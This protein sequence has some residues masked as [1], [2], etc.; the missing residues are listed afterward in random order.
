MRRF[1][2]LLLALTMLAGISPA[3][4]WA[5]EVSDEKILPV[6]DGIASENIAVY[7]LPYYTN[8]D[9]LS[10]ALTGQ[11]I[12]YMNDGDESSYAGLYIDPAYRYL[13]IKGA[14]IF[15]FQQQVCVTDFV[16][17]MNNSKINRYSIECSNDRENW[18]TLAT[19]VYPK[20]IERISFPVAKARW[21]RLC[22][23]S[24]E[25]VPQFKEIEI[26][27]ESEEETFEDKS[28]LIPEKSFG[29]LTAHADKQLLTEL[30]EPADAK[31]VHEDENGD[32]VYEA[33]DENG[34]TLASWGRVGYKNGEEPIPDI[35]T[36]VTVSPNGKDDTKAIQAA[37]DQVAAMPLKENGFRGAIYLEKGTYY[38]SDAI[39][40]NH[41]GIV[42]RGAGNTESGED[43]TLL[44]GTAPKQYKMFNFVGL[45]NQNTYEVVGREYE[46][47]GDYLGTG[48]TEIPL[49]STEGLKKGDKIIVYR[50]P[51]EAWISSLRM[52][53]LGGLIV[54]DGKKPWNY[55]LYYFQFERK[56]ADVK[57]NSIVIDIPL[58]Q[59]MERAYGM[60]T[61]YK[62]NAP[63]RISNCGIEDLS[64][65][66]Y[67]DETVVSSEGTLIDEQ[68]L[69]TGVFFDWFEDGWARNISVKHVVYGA[70]MVDD[71]GKNVTVSD[72]SVTDFVSQIT[73][74][75]RYSFN[76]D[77]QQSLVINCYAKS[78]RHDYVISARAGRGPNAAVN[79]VA[80]DQRNCTE[81]HQRY[82]TG[83]LWDNVICKGNDT[84]GMCAIQRGA[85]GTGQGWSGNHMMFWNCASAFIFIM[86]PPGGQNFAVGNGEILMLEDEENGMGVKI[87]EVTRYLD[88]V[89]AVSGQQFYYQG[90]PFVG[91]GYFELNDRRAS[92]SSLYE[93]Q[94]V[95]AYKDLSY[96]F[97]EGQN[98]YV[99]LNE[100]RETENS[101]CLQGETM[102]IPL[103]QVQ[104]VLDGKS[105]EEILTLAA[106][107]VTEKDGVTYLPMRKVFEAAGLNVYYDEGT[108]TV[109]SYDKSFMQ[110]E[111]YAKVLKSINAKIL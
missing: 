5:E 111:D 81:T 54:G 57:E 3:G 74:G 62:Y 106:G 92:I 65:D 20:T 32:L 6:S 76:L 2:P 23:L 15:D 18:T 14:I 66:S 91:N 96:F 93:R 12:G 94:H 97:R 80:E 104:E 8:F 78:G 75:R 22:I 99:Y 39:N 85:T 11:P 10:R 64:I 48:T 70:V 45:E 67:Y 16:L 41:S 55:S 30:Q 13:G 19:D 24:S 88:W 28:M 61:V 26:Y 63:G 72:C 68:H 21:F 46:I 38:I 77:G 103:A 95:E 102:M 83:F 4:V 73:G 29:N 43:G 7:T 47:Q 59:S 35:E 79:S 100:K 9:G 71:Y 51:T 36:V 27:N 110:D 87:S 42:I 56:I 1:L 69:H 17:K 52:D 25:Y 108:V 90:E 60:G 33:Y 58:V 101:L 82:A 109:T 86:K 84:S 49:D 50:P 89:R 53:A 105:E 37:V 31:L 98:G 44:I 40:I 107:D 34:Q